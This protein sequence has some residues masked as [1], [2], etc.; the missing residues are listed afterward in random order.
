MLRYVS[1][2]PP[3]FV[4]KRYPK[5][6]LPVNHGS[7]AGAGFSTAAGAWA[8][9]AVVSAGLAGSTGACANTGTITKRAV[10]NFIGAA[11]DPRTNRG[12]ADDRR[13]NCGTARRPDCETPGER[14]P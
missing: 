7:V 11:P 1:W 10:R 12:L 8:V 13:C 5:S 2:L 6:M 14:F 9:S 3:M 4:R